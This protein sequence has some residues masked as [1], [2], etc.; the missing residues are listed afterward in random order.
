MQWAKD[1]HSTKS[2]STAVYF[3]KQAFKYG[4]RVKGAREFEL[5]TAEEE[6]DVYNLF[7]NPVLE[8]V[9]LYHYLADK[10]QRS[11][12]AIQWQRVHIF[13]HYNYHRNK[14]AIAL[15]EQLNAIGV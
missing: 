10:L 3:M 4:Y 5:W 8:D 15:N 2:F 6:M 13:T 1:K 12:H 14:W 11:Y 7:F 9:V